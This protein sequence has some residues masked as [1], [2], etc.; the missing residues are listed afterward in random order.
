MCESKTINFTQLYTTT[1]T[2]KTMSECPVCYETM[3]TGVYNT[4]CGHAFHKKC[5]LRWLEKND[6]CPMCRDSV[7]MIHPRCNATTIKGTRCSFRAFGDLETCRRHIVPSQALL[8][9]LEDDE[10][11]INC[12]I[13]FFDGP[14]AL[15]LKLHDS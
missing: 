7:F 6:T 2:N 5:M 12:L 14:L 1:A 15:A 11:E 10:D 8:S 13:M 9:T 3:T 4:E